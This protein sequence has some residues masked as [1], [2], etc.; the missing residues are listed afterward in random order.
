M[1]RARSKAA[2]K[3]TKPTSS[4]VDD[5]AAGPVAIDSSEDENEGAAVATGYVRDFISGVRV[6][7]TPEEVQATQIFSRRLVE[8]FS[9]PINHITTRPQFRVSRRPSETKK[10]Y[11]VDIAVFSSTQKLEDDC[12]IIVECKSE[13]EKA[14][15]KQLEIYLTLSDAFV[16][17]WFNGKSHLYL[18]K[19]YEGGKVYFRELPTLPKFGQRVQDIGLYKR[20]DLETSASLKAVFRDIRHHLAGNTVGITH[21]IR[22]A[23]QIIN[24][25]FCK[26]YDETTKGPDELVEFRAGVDESARAVRDRVLGLFTSVKTR[27]NDVFD[28]TETI[29]LDEKSLAYVVG[30]LQP[31]CITESERDAVGDAFEVFMGPAL[32]GEEGQFFTPRNVIKMIVDVIDPKPEELIIDPACGT[33]G[34]LVTALD[35]VWRSLEGEEE[36]IITRTNS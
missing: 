33:G 14:G 29:E 7:A 1:A 5:A 26:I 18:H 15:R 21:D 32:R 16:G 8:D 28:R 12:I 3:S 35:H 27:F 9:Y 25:L 24:V 34:F 30:E 6:R 11:P 17:V 10:S 4:E 2:A 31:Y 20:A 19:Y 36:E 23:H 22:L 13:T